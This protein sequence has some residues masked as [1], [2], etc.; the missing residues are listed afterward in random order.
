MT[1]ARTPVRKQEKRKF[2]EV[3]ISPIEKAPIVNK[4]LKRL[5]RE[6]CSLLRSLDTEKIF[7]YEV[8]DDVA[9]GYSDEIENPICILDMVGKVQNG[10]YESMEELEADVKLMFNN[11]V[12][13]NG[14]DSD[15]GEVGILLCC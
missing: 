12:Q 6:A 13:F 8:T 11:C 2:E 4:Q 7:E 10:E 1:T 5:L 9:P 15:L 3:E 14:E